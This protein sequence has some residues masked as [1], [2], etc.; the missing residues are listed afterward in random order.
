MTL[1]LK[2]HQRSEDTVE[3]VLSSGNREIGKLRLF[4][5]TKEE[6]E[7]FKK[8]LKKKL[9]VGQPFSAKVF[10]NAELDDKSLGD[11][12]SFVEERFPETKGKVYL[13]RREGEKLTPLK[14]GR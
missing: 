9:K 8:Y 14:L 2:E 4:L 6:I 7:S 1:D 12:L 13:L 11:V 3:Y 5:A 10:L